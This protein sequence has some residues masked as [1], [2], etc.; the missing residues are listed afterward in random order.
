MQ[1][2][3]NSN[4]FRQKKASLPTSELVAKRGCLVIKKT[5]HSFFTCSVSH[6][7]L[8]LRPPIHLWRRSIQ[9]AVRVPLA[10]HPPALRAY[11]WPALLPHGDPGH[12]RVGRVWGY[13]RGV[14]GCTEG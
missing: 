1:S 5:I 9:P 6:R 14:S 2:D 8:G 7:R 3:L 4:K 10:G 13:R 11:S 12:P